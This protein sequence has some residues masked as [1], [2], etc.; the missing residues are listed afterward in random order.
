MWVYACLLQLIALTFDLKEEKKISL[1]SNFCILGKSDVRDISFAQREF[2]I[3][4][5]QT[6]YPIQTFSREGTL[7][8]CVVQKD[9]LNEVRFF[10]L[11]QQLHIIVTDGST[12][13]VKILSNEGKLIAQFG[14]KGPAAGKFTNIRGVA[15]Y[16]VGTIITVGE[17]DHNTLQAFSLT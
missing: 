5:D 4:F 10:C 12:T 8:R 11:D 6:E 3:L 2:Y 13:Q 15:V 9:L 17:K 1:N 7:I 14:E 16:D